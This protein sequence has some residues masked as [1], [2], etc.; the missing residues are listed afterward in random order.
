MEEEIKI[1]YDLEQELGLVLDKLKAC[2][3]GIFK[4]NAKLR[5]LVIY[6]EDDTFMTL[7]VTDLLGYTVNHYPKMNS[8][9]IRFSDTSKYKTLGEFLK[10]PVEW[11]EWFN[12]LILG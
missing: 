7:H 12:K 4:P 10:N 1:V 6:E 2:A 5:E 8:S 3:I 11:A 9:F